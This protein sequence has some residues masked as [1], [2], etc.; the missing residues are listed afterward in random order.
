MSQSDI[1]TRIDSLLE[2]LE[3]G[4]LLERPAL[5]EQI[6]ALGADAIAGLLQRSEHSQAKTALRELV[7]Q[8]EG[9]E[10]ERACTM[11]RSGVRR[12]RAVS[13]RMLALKLLGEYFT[14]LT[15]FIEK[16]VETA[17]DTGESNEVRARALL[18][19]AAAALDGATA[20]E[21]SGK[22]L[23]MEALG[24]TEKAGLRAAAF[25]C[26]VEH[27]EHL[28]VDV[29]MASLDPFLIAEGA[30]VR[31]LGLKL[32]AAVG[33]IDAVERI[34]MLP[35]ANEDASAQTAIE[36]I[37]A[38]PINLYALRWEHFEHFVG[39][40]LRS[41]GHLDVEITRTVRDDGVDVISYREREDFGRQTRE[42][43][44]V[45]CKRWTKSDVDVKALEEFVCRSREQDAK[46][47][48]FI[49]TS[50]YTKRAQD[51]ADAHLNA[52]EIIDGD[53]LIGILER[54]FGPGRYVIR[55]RD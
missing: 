36:T 50:G 41:M 21:L 8:L 17:L 10:R 11:L 54:Q 3:R 49:T 5:L 22:L 34:A 37:L 35:T 1:E 6:V 18:T 4:D 13:A 26:F 47:A 38:R 32:L 19:L 20:R 43:W 42:R 14:D 44:V 9:D 45:Q 30:G 48:L 7:A 24:G 39:Q 40:L 46:H 28:P 2:Q 33:D 12:D 53:Q 51:Y 23:S 29:T 55:G 15:G 16:V 31:T 25:E 27:A 52:I